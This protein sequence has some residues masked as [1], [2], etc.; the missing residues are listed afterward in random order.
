MDSDVDSAREEKSKKS[1]REEG[2]TF[3]ERSRVWCVGFSLLWETGIRINRRD[4]IDVDG[5]KWNKWTSASC[6]TRILVFF[7]TIDDVRP[8]TKLEDEP[9]S[10]LSNVL[11]NP[12]ILSTY[13]LCITKAAK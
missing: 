2:S 1:P 7:F 11:G 6:R 4:E 8:R 9:S 12:M 5:E 13:F 10:P 3:P